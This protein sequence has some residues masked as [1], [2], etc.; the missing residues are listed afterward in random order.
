MRNGNEKE[1]WG[2]AE[3]PQ[4]DS[5]RPVNKNSIQQQQQAN[6]GQ[7]QATPQNAHCPHQQSSVKKS[8]SSSFSQF[9][10]ETHPFQ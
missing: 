7:G 10:E 6:Q 8:K 5:D 1:E 2:R 9:P 4:L 3:R